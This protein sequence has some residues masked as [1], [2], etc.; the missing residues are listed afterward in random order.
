MGAKHP[1]PRFPLTLAGFMVL[2]PVE[3]EGKSQPEHTENCDDCRAHG[4]EEVNPTHPGTL[5]RC[6]G[7]P[8]PSPRVPAAPSRPVRGRGQGYLP[9][10]RP[11][12]KLGQY[13]ILGG[14]RLFGT[15]DQLCSGSGNRPAVKPSGAIPSVPRVAARCLQGA[16]VRRAERV[17]GGGLLPG[18]RQ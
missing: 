8:A 2:I 7:N 14:L 10:P 4:Q 17:P 3:G 9:Y 15:E 5:S 11:V 6:R 13:R 18:M 1:Q 12:F 16:L